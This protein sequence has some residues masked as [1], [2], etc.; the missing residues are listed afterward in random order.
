MYILHTYILHISLYIFII[1]IFRRN[2][3]YNLE[4]LNS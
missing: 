4:F 3:Y 1:I 2:Q